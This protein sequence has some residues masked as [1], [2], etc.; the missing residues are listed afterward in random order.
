MP[1]TTPPSHETLSPW[2]PRSVVIV[3]IFG[4]AV[5]I[6]MSLRA[7]Q[8]APPI[9]VKAVAPGGEVVFTAE[10]VAAGQEVFLK[11]G[12]MNNGTIWG[13]GGYLGPDFSAQTLHGL[14]L[15]FAGRIAQTQF[16]NAVRQPRENEKAAVDGAVA[17]A[18][19]TNRYDAAT[20]YADPA[21][22]QQGGVHRA[23]RVLDELLR[24]PGQEW[25]ALERRGRRSERAAQA[26]RVLRL[27]RLGFGRPTARQR[28]IPTPTTSPTIRW[29][30]ITTTGGAL[31]WSAISLVFLLGGIAVVLLAFGKFD[32]LGWHGGTT[33]AAARPA[34]VRPAQITPAQAATVKFMVVAGLLFLAQVLIGGARRALSRRAGRLLRLRPVGCVPEQSAARLASADGDLLGR[35]FLRRRRAVR[36]LG[37]RRRR[38]EG[39]APARPPAL[40]RARRGRRRQ[41]ARPVGRHLQRCSASCGSGS[42]TRAGNTW[43]S[44]ASGRSCSRRPALLVLAGAGARSRPR[45]RNP[46]L[47]PFVDFFLIAAFA[48]PLFYLPA[49]L[50]RREDPLLHR[51]RLAVLDHPS[52]GRGLLRV[53]RHGDRRRSSS[54]SSAWSGAS[55]RSASSI[56][57]PSSYFGGG[58]IGTGAPLVLHRPDRA[59]HGARRHVLRARGRAAHAAH[60]RCLG[61]LP[62]HAR[63]ER[64]PPFRH[65]WT[66]F[67]L[68]A[69]GFWNFVGAG[70]FGFL[71]NTPIVSYY[72]VGHDPHG[73]PRPRRVHRRL[74][75]AG[76]RRSWPTCCARSRPT[77]CGRGS[78]SS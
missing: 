20:R 2:W 50:L 77:R 53:L 78:R 48:I 15:Y 61:F 7:Y 46:E 33:A 45:A 6:L 29:S 58:L 5:L 59:Q 67:F 41:P 63:R 66:F 35:D 22:R 51:R 55:R 40:R 8:N 71:I 37:A 1:A 17:S 10:D 56:S 19:K 13:H 9:P 3:M 49:L 52:V 34:N 23:G 73:Q 4:F 64:A 26:H 32:Y 30:A 47:R 65:R 68:M 27:D 12:L 74:R 39:P 36:R 38:P 44:G 24:R 16:Q 21:R 70:V 72:E 76:R 62:A 18:F 42:A 54:S 43:R 60:A 69:V 25:R 57:T 75:H 11:Y 14:A 28:R 31:L